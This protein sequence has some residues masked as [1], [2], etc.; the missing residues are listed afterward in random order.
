MTKRVWILALVLAFFSP[1]WAHAK[2][3]KPVNRNVSVRRV[4][5]KKAKHKKVRRVKSKTHAS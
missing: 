3:P 5:P 2:K 1:G 4:K